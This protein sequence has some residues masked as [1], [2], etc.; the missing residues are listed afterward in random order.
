MNSEIRTPAPLTE[1]EQR[2]LNAL[3][4]AFAADKFDLAAE[5]IGLV[6]GNLFYLPDEDAVDIEFDFSDGLKLDDRHRA[7]ILKFLG[8]W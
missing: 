7:A 5:E 3:V 6:Q 2:Q 1:V 4:A 8:D